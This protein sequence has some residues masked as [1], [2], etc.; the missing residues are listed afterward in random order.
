MACSSRKAGAFHHEPLHPP[1]LVGA[2]VQVGPRHSA[3]QVGE[4]GD[5]LGALGFDVIQRVGNLADRLGLRRGGGRLLLV[6][7]EPAND[8]HNDPPSPD[9]S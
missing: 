8:A 5:V 9:N 2:D 7:P 6:Q 3:E 4:A 1:R